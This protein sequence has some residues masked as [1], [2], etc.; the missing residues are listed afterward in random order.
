MTT[1]K[2]TSKQDIVSKACEPSERKNLEDM[3]GLLATEFHKMMP[4]VLIRDYRAL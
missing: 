2:I 1:M 4:I 3:I